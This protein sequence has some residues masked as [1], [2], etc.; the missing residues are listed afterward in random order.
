ME[1]IN[2]TAMGQLWD[3]VH[4]TSFKR[5]GEKTVTASLLI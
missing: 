4:I 5:I 2:F 3:G 1:E